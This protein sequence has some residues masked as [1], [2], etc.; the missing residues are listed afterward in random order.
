[1]TLI[2][3]L[4]PWGVAPAV[5]EKQDSYLNNM[6]FLVAL[7]HFDHGEFDKA[8]EILHTLSEQG[9]TLA[10]FHIGYMYNY[11]FGVKRDYATAMQ[12][13]KQAVINVPK[14]SF[15]IGFMHHKG[16]GVPKNLKYAYMWWEIAHQQGHKYA[17]RYKKIATRKMKDKEIQYAD[18]RAKQCMES[19]FQ[20]CQPNFDD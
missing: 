8:L 19:K 12:W 15:Y 18:N 3:L 13:Y 10:K 1:M 4:C 5:A 9:D 14:A 11:G 6:E 20:D 2:A 16:Q 7:N 17:E